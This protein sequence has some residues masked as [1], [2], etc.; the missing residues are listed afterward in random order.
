MDKSELPNENNSKKILAGDKTA[1][2]LD[3]GKITLTYKDQ[4]SWL[5]QVENPFEEEITLE[6][7]PKDVEV[8]LVLFKKM[9][10][11]YK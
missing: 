6:L 4:L 10:E 1:L 7:R 11:R 9:W 3:H 2:I 5:L 8:L